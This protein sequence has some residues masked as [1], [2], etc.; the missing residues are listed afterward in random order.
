MMDAATWSTVQQLFERAQEHPPDA[1]HS[2]LRGKCQ[3]EEIIREV[4]SLLAAHSAVPVDFL[5]SENTVAQVGYRVDPASLSG[6]Q[7]ARI[8]LSNS[9]HKAA[10]EPSTWHIRKYQPET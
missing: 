6:T 10:W 9:S 1:R 4:E 5:E 7:L 2:F 8:T 3:D